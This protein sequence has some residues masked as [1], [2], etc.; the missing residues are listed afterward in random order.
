LGSKFKTKERLDEKYGVGIKFG[1][2]VSLKEITC[3]NRIDDFIKNCSLRGW[4]VNKIDVQNRIDIYNVAEE[5]ID[6][7]D[8]V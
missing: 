4:L 3:V 6:F 1:I 2:V 7:N 8:L 5:E